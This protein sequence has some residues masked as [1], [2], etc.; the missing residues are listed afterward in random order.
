MRGCY[1]KPNFGAVVGFPV[2]IAV[3]ELALRWGPR[4][5]VATCM[6]SVS[7]LLALATLAGGSSLVILPLLFTAQIASIADASA[8]ASGAVGAADPGRRGASLAL[9]AFTGYVA[10]FVGPVVVGIALDAFGG[11]AWAMRGARAARRR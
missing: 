6:V 11:A 8:L 9:F 7:V 1:S 5:V 2:A 4:A 10:A 3:A